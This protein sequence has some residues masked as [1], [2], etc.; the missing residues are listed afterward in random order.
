MAGPEER[1]KW[2]PSVG[3]LKAPPL[4]DQGECNYLSLETAK[5]RC[6][7]PPTAPYITAEMRKNPWIVSQKARTARRIA[8]DPPENAWGAF[9]YRDKLPIMD[10]IQPSPPPGR[11]P[12]WRMGYLRSVGCPAR[13]NGRRDESRD[14]RKCYY[15]TNLRQQGRNIRPGAFEVPPS[16][17]RGHRTPDARGPSR[18][19]RY[20]SGLR[21]RA[22]LWKASKGGVKNGG[23]C[24]KGRKGGKGRKKNKTVRAR[25]E[26]GRPTLP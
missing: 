8:E 21:R 7:K 25:E 24:K 20:P 23:G 5:E 11:R 19:T 9:D 6:E 2:P 16:R 18:Q 3:N 10:H 4:P 22:N 17:K 12:L 1:R 14:S 26:V 13:P 15:I